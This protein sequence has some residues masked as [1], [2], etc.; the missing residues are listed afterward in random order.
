MEQRWL[1]RLKEGSITI[2][3]EQFL[4]QKLDPDMAKIF[5]SKTNSFQAR[6]FEDDKN[7][8]FRD[9][10]VIDASLKAALTQTTKNDV[11]IGLNV[12]TL[13]QIRYLRQQLRFHQYM[14]VI[15]IANALLL[16][17]YILAKIHQKI[18]DYQ[19][20][21]H[22]ERAILVRQEREM[23]LQQLRN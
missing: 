1:Q 21:K 10:E 11:T 18:K 8:I 22:L 2:A 7:S 13:K 23:L 19:R 6:L 9:E 4:V 14:P 20:K 3:G 16:I 15:Y 12:E 5:R 17:Y